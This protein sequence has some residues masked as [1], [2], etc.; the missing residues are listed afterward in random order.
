[1]AIERGHVICF[2]K[3]LDEGFRK[4]YDTLPFLAIEKTSI[5]IG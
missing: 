4:I 3:G 5:A 1:M 2:W